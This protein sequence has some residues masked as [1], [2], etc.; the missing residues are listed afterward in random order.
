MNEI[1]QK[2]LRELK[3]FVHKP[4]QPKVCYGNCGGI[5]VHYWDGIC[6]VCRE[7]NTGRTP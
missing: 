4:P 7:C 3:N 1:I 6:W 5:T 2:T